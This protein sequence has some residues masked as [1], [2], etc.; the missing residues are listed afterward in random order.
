MSA[1][2][3]CKSH[4]IPIC[5]FEGDVIERDGFIIHSLMLSLLIQ[6]SKE[7]IKI[8]LFIMNSVIK[9]IQ[10]VI[11]NSIKKKLNCKLI[12]V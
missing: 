4:G 6:N 7:F 1:E 10:Q 11:I 12:G 8:K 2:E 5:Y 3:L 9:N